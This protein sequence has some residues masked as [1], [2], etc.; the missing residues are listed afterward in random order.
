MA[1]TIAR[2]ARIPLAQPTLTMPNS[3]GEA[4]VAPVGVWLGCLLQSLPPE[5]RD[6]ICRDVQ[7]YL[8]ATK[9]EPQRIIR[10]A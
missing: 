4:I 3:Q 1:Q 9:Q 10:P 7:R 6:D 5:W 8:A 2:N